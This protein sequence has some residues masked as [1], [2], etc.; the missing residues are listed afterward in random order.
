M[1]S[2]VNSNKEK[3]T[4]IKPTPPAAAK[5]KAKKENNQQAAAE[6]EQ[7][8][9]GSSSNLS[10]DFVAEQV[11]QEF[12]AL[13]TQ[14]KGPHKSCYG[15][16]EMTEDERNRKVVYTKIPDSV[17]IIEQR[18]KNEEVVDVDLIQIAHKDLIAAVETRD[19]KQIELL[20]SAANKGST[21]E[22]SPR[23]KAD[24]TQL[25]LDTVAAL[26]GNNCLTEKKVKN[27]LKNNKTNKKNNH[28]NKTNKILS[29]LV[30]L[31]SNLSNNDEDSDDEDSDNDNDDYD[32]S[33]DDDESTSSSNSSSDDENRKKKSSTS[34][35]WDGSTKLQFYSTLAQK[36]TAESARAAKFNSKSITSE[37]LTI[38]YKITLAYESGDVSKARKKEVELYKKLTESFGL[39]VSAKA[40]GLDTIHRAVTQGETNDGTMNKVNDHSNDVFNTTFSPLVE[41]S[42]DTFRKHPQPHQEQLSSFD[43]CRD[44]IYGMTGQIAPGITSVVNNDEGT[45]KIKFD[46]GISSAIRE[47]CLVQCRILKIFELLFKSE[48]KKNSKLRNIELYVGHLKKVQTLIERK[49]QVICSEFEPISD[50]TYCCCI[51]NSEVFAG[52]S[53]LGKIRSLNIDIAEEHFYIHG[54]KMFSE[55][56]RMREDEDIATFLN[57]M[58]ELLKETRELSAPNNLHLIGFPVLEGRVGHGLDTEKI[59]VAILVKQLQSVAIRRDV[60]VSN[61]ITKELIT[62]S[63]RGELPLDELYEVNNSMTSN[64]QTIGCAIVKKSKGI[65]QTQS[66][67]SLSENNRNNKGGFKKK[68][69]DGGTK[70]KSKNDEGGG[71]KGKRVPGPSKEFKQLRYKKTAQK[72]YNADHDTMKKNIVSLMDRINDTTI[73]KCGKK[74]FDVNKNQLTDSKINSYFGNWYKIRPKDGN[75]LDDHDWVDFECIRDILGT[76][77]FK[78]LSY[79]GLYY[80]REHQNKWSQQLELWRSFI[81]PTKNF[82]SISS[83]KKKD[84]S[85]KQSHKK[86]QAAESS[87]EEDYDNDDDDTDIGYDTSSTNSSTSKSSFSSSRSGGSQ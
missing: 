62:R 86:I 9:Q 53:I 51:V 55:E 32:N 1:S 8:G 19:E 39:E 22:K 59:F 30:N 78:T 24:E 69:N 40:A 45:Q 81:R 29:V 65:S 71:S 3:V 57:R 16:E 70:K 25:P 20:W 79:T 28:K 42:P 41:N 18:L 76:S 52:S 2:K 14:A 68:K 67:G 37:E 47:R 6:S 21:N 74:F 23:L 66:F 44:K 83:K 82:S 56:G 77:R 63:E 72:V 84:Q 43:E 75:H 33:I 38:A 31:L 49:S 5:T 48:L 73:K 87:C 12:I 61:Y 58:S 50:I 11:Q 60:R 64:G 34:K 36:K 54:F 13:L 35:K 7:D 15:Y 85:K 10:E 80:E 4:Q 17:V 26:V 46:S 27:L